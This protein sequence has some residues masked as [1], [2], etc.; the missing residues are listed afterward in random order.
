MLLEE[1]VSCLCVR[2]FLSPGVYPHPFSDGFRS[3]YIHPKEPRMKGQHWGDKWEAGAVGP[4]VSSGE[5]QGEKWLV[6][7]SRI[8]WPRSSFNLSLPNICLHCH[9]DNVRTHPWVSVFGSEISGIRILL[10]C[11]I[12]GRDQGLPGVNA[13]LGSE[14]RIIIIT[15]C[16]IN[17]DLGQPFPG[18]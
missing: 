1:K 9:C 7:V 10:A 5:R 13:K 14:S 11:R 18:F 12:L 15:C 8:C 16:Q 6:P 2:L 3:H 17:F 4:I